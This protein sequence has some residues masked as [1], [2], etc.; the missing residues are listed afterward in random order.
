MHEEFEKLRSHKKNNY[1]LPNINLIYSKP[2]SPLAVFLGK[3]LKKV[4]LHK[5]IRAT[6]FAQKGLKNNLDY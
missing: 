5:F 3:A 2:F 4:L 6:F 1:C